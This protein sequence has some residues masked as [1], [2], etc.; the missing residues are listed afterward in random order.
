MNVVLNHY[1][2]EYCAFLAIL[3]LISHNSPAEL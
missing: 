1:V 3:L 2:D